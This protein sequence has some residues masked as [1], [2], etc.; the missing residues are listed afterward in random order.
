M[1][2]KRRAGADLPPLAAAE[3]HASA[4]AETVETPGLIVVDVAARADAGGAATVEVFGPE[5]VEPCLKRRLDLTEAFQTFWVAIHGHLLPNGPASL[6]FVLRDDHGRSLA[7]RSLTVKVRNVGALAEATRASLQRSAAP[8]AVDVCDSTTYDY[9]DPALAPW[10][11]REPEAVE[12]HLAA[13]LASGASA[14]EV[15]ALRVFV[16]DGYLV[17]PDVLTPSELEG[18]NAAIDDAVARKVEGYEWG[19]SQRIHNLHRDYPAIRDLWR[20]PKVLRMLSLIFD[21][22]ARPYQSLT[23]VFGSQQKPHQDTVALT[24]FPAGRMCGVWTALE[25]IQPDSG[26]LVVYPGS[27][28]ARRV[29]TQKAGVAKVAGDYSDFGRGFNPLWREIIADTPPEHYRPKAGTVLIWHENLMHGGAVRIDRSKTRR[30]IVCHYFA[31]GCVGYH[32][33]SGM[34]GILAL[35]EG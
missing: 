18:L 27:H 30:S 32:D 4:V 22:P 5:A 12:A 26:E 2:F 19:A 33:A 34:P 8:L 21:S 10:H 25:D 17:V 13:L 24:P 28:R 6:R 15:E 16:T 3:L 7:E 11:D 23:Y 20:H 31:D 29:Y 9:A 14:Q 1:F 35:P